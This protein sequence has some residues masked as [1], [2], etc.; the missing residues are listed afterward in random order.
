MSDDQA[1]QKKKP[2]F[3]GRLF[4][5]KHVEPPPDIPQAVQPVKVEPLPPAPEPES[6]KSESILAR[7]WDWMNQPLFVHEKPATPTV[8]PPLS[9]PENASFDAIPSLP[10]IA[11]DP[12]NWFDKLKEKVKKGSGGFVTAVRSAV[13]LSG[14]LDDE[15]TDRLE[16]ILIG[17]D[18]GMA[19]AIKIV[20]RM[21]QRARD[22]GTEGVDA[23][24]A[25]FKDELKRVFEGNIKPFAPKPA[26]D[27]PYVVMVVGVNGVGKTTTIGKMAK[28]CHDAGLKTMLVAGDTFR[29]AAIEQL[30]IWA[31]RSGSEFMKS[32]HGSDPSGLVFDALT[33]AKARGT[34]VVFI[35]T[36]GRLQ[37]KTD[38]MDELGKVSRVA[39]KILPGAPHETLLVIDA[40]TGQNAVSQVKAFTGIVPLNGL[41]MTKLD[42]TAKGGIL[43]TI[44]DQFDIPVTLIGVGEGVDDLRDFDPDQYAAALFSDESGAP[45]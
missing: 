11:E 41:V 10:V 21:K 17:A 2:G 3:F 40:T 20:D 34:D 33:A 43:I 9:T 35:D 44:R 32:K 22:E 13:G 18:V 15:T 42:G 30:E 31:K 7:T 23:I 26:T 1:D 14:R 5:S 24:M 25:L 36:A 4:T 38:L 12:R 27:G 19:T 6:D 37:T 8:P 39:A 28:R 45:K 16:E 29:A